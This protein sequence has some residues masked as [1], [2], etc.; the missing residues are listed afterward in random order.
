VEGLSAVVIG[1][2]GALAAFGFLFCFLVFFQE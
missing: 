2:R 1:V